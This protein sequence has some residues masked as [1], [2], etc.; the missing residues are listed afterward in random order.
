MVVS[1]IN[2]LADLFLLI[3]PIPVIMGLNLSFRKRVGLSAVF[4]TGLFGTGVAILGL[5]YRVR[6]FYYALKGDES[7]QEALAEIIM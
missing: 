2:L 3:I 7:W 4:L 5:Y 1:V 6:L